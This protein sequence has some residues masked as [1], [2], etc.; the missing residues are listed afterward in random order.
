[1][2]QDGKERPGFDARVEAT[3]PR[4][5]PAEARVA[6]FFAARKEAVVLSSAAQIAAAVGA[7]D[8]TVVRTARSLGYASL[9]ELREDILAELTGAASPARL[10]SHTLDAAGGSPAGILNHVLELHGEALAALA[11][12][13]FAA[14]F[15]RALD[16]IAAAGMRHV[17]GIGPSGA[18]ADYAALQ[19]NRIGLRSQALTVPGVGLADRLAW[20]S[21]GD[22]V[23]MIAYA[24]LY[25]EV[26]VLLDRAEA[27]HVPVVLISDSLGPLVAGRVAEVLPVPRGRS[28]HL[29]LHGAT[30]VLIE[31][32]SLGLAALDREAAVE[33]LDRLSALR[34]RID[35]DWIK[36]GTRR[37]GP[38][39]SAPQPDEGREE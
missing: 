14:A 33:A 12:P 8:A 31:A 28:G 6:L 29:A 20:L 35:R 26:E 13:D 9:L 1:M 24:P 25:R 36:R 4:L 16:L 39:V 10:L 38:P 27:A 21:P 22:A 11:R 23:V 15:A 19:F 18:V 37:P 3:V 5:T 34:G 17:F 2:T 7:S 32:L 30:L